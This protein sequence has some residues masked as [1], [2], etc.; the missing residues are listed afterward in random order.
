MFFNLFDFFFLFQLNATYPV[1]IYVHGGRFI[2]NSAELYQPNYLLERDI[3][4]VV[5]Q[6][7]LNALGN[8][9]FHNL[10]APK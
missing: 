10:F 5:I 8:F 2:D 1:M 6:Y 9:H 7:R 4:L 3:V